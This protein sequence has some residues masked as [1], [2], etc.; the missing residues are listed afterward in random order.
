VLS[1]HVSV[2]DQAIIDL[3]RLYRDLEGVSTSGNRGGGRDS[4]ALYSEDSEWDRSGCDA[5]DSLLGDL[6]VERPVQWWHVTERYL[7]CEVRPQRIKTARG[8]LPSPGAHREFLGHGVRPPDLLSGGE[9]LV[10]VETWQPT[11]RLE[12]VRRGIRFLVV[13]FPWNDFRW[14]DL[15]QE[16]T[17]A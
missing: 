10:V 13:G 7:R 1:Q 6:R 3:L 11:V 8:R 9:V 14:R 16:M 4:R 17:A 2:R 12:K 15:R 5:L